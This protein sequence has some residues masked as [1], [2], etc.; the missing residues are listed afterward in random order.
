MGGGALGRLIG[1]LPLGGLA[2][3]TPL[4]LAPGKP[5]QSLADS[6]RNATAQSTLPLS[7]T[8]AMVTGRVRGELPEQELQLQAIKDLELQH[9]SRAATIRPAEEAF[10]GEKTMMM[11]AETTE[12]LEPGRIMSGPE[13]I[14]AHGQAF[15]A[16]TS[17]DISV[18]ARTGDPTKPI[19]AQFLPMRVGKPVVHRMQV[20]KTGEYPSPT[21]KNLAKQLGITE[22]AV[23]LMGPQGRRALAHA[24]RPVVPGVL[25]RS[26]FRQV[27]PLSIETSFGHITEVRGGD[28]LDFGGTGV[29][30]WDR[31][32][33]VLPDG[34]LMRFSRKP[35]YSETFY[36]ID[37]KTG[38]WVLKEPSKVNK[39]WDAVA[40][41]EASPYD[42]SRTLIDVEKEAAKP[43][44]FAQ[45]IIATRL[46]INPEQEGMS[47]MSAG[48][49]HAQ[50]WRQRQEG[51]PEIGGRR[52]GISKDKLYSE[53]KDGEALGDV[54]HTR[55]AR[56]PKQ[57]DGR[58]RLAG[59]IK[60]FEL[61]KFRQTI[62]IDP[63]TTAYHSK[64]DIDITKRWNEMARMSPSMFEEQKRVALLLLDYMPDEFVDGLAVSI[65]GRIPS[66]TPG[67]ATAAH[68]SFDGAAGIMTLS[69]ADADLHT[70]YHEFFHHLHTWLPEEDLI[71]I[72]GEWKRALLSKDTQNLISTLYWGHHQR[73]KTTDDLLALIKADS[74]LQQYWHSITDYGNRAPTD[75]DWLD[76][77]VRMEDEGR[78]PENFISEVYWPTG[79]VGSK[80]PLLGGPGMGWS[81]DVND[82]QRVSRWFGDTRAS[83]YGN[84]PTLK[85]LNELSAIAYRF[86]NITEFMAEVFANR[87]R[88]MMLAA[89][90]KSQRNRN[91]L[92]RI[93]DL[94]REWMVTAY[95]FARRMGRK[96]TIDHIWRKITN[97][98]YHPVDDEAIQRALDT[99]V[100]EWNYGTGIERISEEEKAV[101]DAEEGYVGAWEEA[102]MSKI[103]E[104]RG[105]EY[106]RK[107][108][109]LG[110]R[111]EISMGSGPFAEDVMRMQMGSI[112]MGP[113]DATRKEMRDEIARRREEYQQAVRG[114]D[115]PEPMQGPGAGLWEQPSDRPPR[116]PGMPENLS[117]EQLPQFLRGPE[118]F[119]RQAE[120]GGR[121]SPQVRPAPGGAAPQ[122]RAEGGAPAPFRFND[123]RDLILQMTNGEVGFVMSGR[124]KSSAPG[125]TA[126]EFDI[127]TKSDDEFLKIGESTLN[128]KGADEER[129][130]EGIINLE[131]NPEYRGTGQGKR[132]VD[133]LS[134]TAPPG[135]G[136]MVYDIQPEAEGFWK[137]VAGDRFESIQTRKG[138]TTRARIGAADSPGT[139]PQM[140][141]EGGGELPFKI[142]ETFT[143][144]VTG[145]NI[146]RSGVPQGPNAELNIA[147][148]R[149]RVI[150]NERNNSFWVELLRTEGDPSIGSL[151]TLKSF[152]E[153]LS[154]ENPGIGFK[155]MAHDA[156]R[157]RVYERA[158]FTVE[159]V[160]EGGTA[161]GTGRPLTEE[162]SAVILSMPP[163]EQQ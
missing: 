150:F 44:S 24:Q 116:F 140:R 149:T 131:L 37:K 158:G 66:G 57:I 104:V 124:A 30:G 143:E 107:S 22:E 159:S 160:M 147:G 16:P 114:M 11:P 85:A 39:H 115:Y 58:F 76:I 153:D 23:N 41:R 8:P 48:R 109:R 74:G 100:D 42:P 77:I 88:P 18:V 113:T 128:I 156:K 14:A 83:L 49:A 55:V 69:S 59:L 78:L 61:S 80:R 75:D 126:I 4:A 152:I 151:R 123:P 32:F 87:I 19:H 142:P 110:G 47:I 20:T 139:A 99:N 27:Y 82:P 71:S 21:A 67:L 5:F 56:G 163:K 3:K 118:A 26:T 127:Y 94:L 46:A 90:M 148:I 92:N 101:I 43:F 106:G 72:T 60:N 145:T 36:D 122:M 12:F 91:I 63:V 31:R 98:S 93:Y 34:T 138:K 45:N 155:I 50:K 6:I 2:K 33:E 1:E 154:S 40:R 146:S 119:V 17:E 129:Y 136:L 97:G 51:G 38:E 135:E 29:H 105:A 81:S 130:V 54:T 144:D 157:A 86:S 28:I 103:R 13:Q 162:E 111:E 117:F 7:E 68:Y 10:P 53:L 84:L 141:A 125:V 161:A 89:D 121:R 133:S 79:V 62:E 132:I 52:K 108:S 112:H 120:F 64:R 96:D 70:W 95:N 15:R 73:I 25:G 137:N 102:P 9:G 65:V 134:Q 35:S